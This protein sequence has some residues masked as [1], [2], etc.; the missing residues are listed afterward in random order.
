[1]GSWST[2]GRR[3]SQIPRCLRSGGGFARSPLRSARR[4]N[5]LPVSW[6]FAAY[7]FLEYKRAAGVADTSQLTLRRRLRAFAAEIC[8]PPEHLSQQ[9]LVHY[10]ASRKA[11]ETPRACRNLFPA[12]FTWFEAAGYRADNPARL[13]PAVR[14]ATP[15][16]KPCTD[17]MISAALERATAEERLMVLLAATC[18]LR[19]G[20]IA[21]VHSSEVITGTHGRNLF[22][23]F[24]TWFE[25][26]GYRADNPARLLPAVRRAT[27][28]PKPCTD[29]MISAALERATAEERL[30]VLLAATCGLRRGEIARVHSSDVITGTHGERSLIVHGKGGKQRIVPL[31]E[32]LAQSIV[33]ADGYLFPGR[34]DGHVEESYI[35]KRVSRLLPPGYSCHKLRHRF[36]TV[37][38]TDSHD[39]LAVAR[40]LGHSSTDTT[41]AYVAL[42]EEALRA[43]MEAAALNHSGDGTMSCDG[44]TQAGGTDLAATGGNEAAEYGRT[45]AGDSADV[46]LAA[47]LL[48]WSMTDS[49][50]GGSRSFRI[51]TA[52]LAGQW[53]LGKEHGRRS[54]VVQTAAKRLEALGVIGR[55]RSC[56]R[57]R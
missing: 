44:T 50:R 56:K 33:A 32:E 37:A 15:H 9:Q 49:I 3:A 23:A 43:L 18:S 42:P 19:R 53:G 31:T 7:G 35:G 8:T 45:D 16:P 27:P 10:R 22:T 20:E 38:Y 40:A 36:A 25:A 39:M 29:D 24:F 4:P 52:S 21:R 30:M 28:H 2:S 6:E 41:Q 57:R 11:V 51:D 14:L 12:F 54:V 17:D 46:L 34:W 5:S 55:H 26:A 48:A 1:M 47:L 13:L